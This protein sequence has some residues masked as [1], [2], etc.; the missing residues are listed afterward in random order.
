MQYLTIVQ[1]EGAHGVGKSTFLNNLEET[2][3]VKIL[4][5]EFVSDVKNS[6]SDLIFQEFHWFMR[7]WDRVEEWIQNPNSLILFTD[8]CPLTSLI[9]CADPMLGSAL[10]VLLHLY[11]DRMEK[12][13]PHVRFLRVELRR[14]FLDNFSLCQ[15]RLQNTSEHEQHIRSNILQENDANW[16]RKIRTMYKQFQTRDTSVIFLDSDTEHATAEKI[17][18]SLQPRLIPPLKLKNSKNEDD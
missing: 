7:W 14:S 9:Y 4:K 15:I 18:Q 12:R 3:E 13:Y 11:Y 2:D 16:L 1:V 6:K 8:R 10:T 17:V 5:E